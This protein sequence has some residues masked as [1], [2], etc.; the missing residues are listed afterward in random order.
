MKR[1]I[2]TLAVCFLLFP[3]L[4]LADPL[5]NPVVQI[6]DTKDEAGDWVWTE[7]TGITWDTTAWTSE[8][9]GDHNPLDDDR[10]HDWFLPYKGDSWHFSFQR[11]VKG[12]YAIRWK[13]ADSIWS[14]PETCTLRPPD[15]AKHKDPAQSTP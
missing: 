11:D 9:V 8:Q 1:F 3:C 15:L 13:Q 10:T 6:A 7:L 2:V 4:V 5:V 14:D 12:E